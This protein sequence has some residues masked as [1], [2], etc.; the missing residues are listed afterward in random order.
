M[1]ATYLQVVYEGLTTYE[2]SP[3]A[4]PSTLFGCLMIL[5]AACVN[6]PCYIDRL[7][8]PFM[9]VLQKMAREHLSPGGIG[10]GAG[11]QES[12]SMGTELLILSL[13]LVKNRVGVMG[14]EMRKAF[15]GAILVGLIEKS[16][17]VKVTPL[18]WPMKVFCTSGEEVVKVVICYTAT[19]S[20][21]R[22]K[23][24][25]QVIFVQ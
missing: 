21:L 19:T 22:H 20:Q 17:D 8:T 11:G 1:R 2:K 3:A 13:D 9:H 18:A 25:L 7:I 23:L 6:H 10:G 5:K 24:A 12:S 15:I 14:Q 16:P 4:P